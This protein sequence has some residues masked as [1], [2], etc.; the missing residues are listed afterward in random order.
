MIKPIYIIAPVMM[1]MAFCC[2]ANG[3]DNTD[4]ASNPTNVS[5]LS[6]GE[7]LTYKL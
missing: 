3:Q 5:W 4:V 1:F 2:E 6:V 7:K